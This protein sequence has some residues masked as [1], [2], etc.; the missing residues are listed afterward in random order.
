MQYSWF[1]TER[2]KYLSWE[3]DIW[4][5]IWANSSNKYSRIFP[6]V[7][8]INTFSYIFTSLSIKVSKLLNKVLTINKWKAKS[9]T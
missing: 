4:P 5:I 7:V 2:L 6:L 8:Y 1:N 9:N 3:V